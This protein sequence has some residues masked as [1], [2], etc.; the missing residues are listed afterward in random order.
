M[1][2]ATIRSP[3]DVTKDLLPQGNRLVVR[4]K[5]DHKEFKPKGKQSVTPSGCRYMR[6]T[7]IWQTVWLEGV[8]TT[9]IRDWTV[10]AEPVSGRLRL[11]MHLDGPAAGLRAS[12]RVSRAGK[13]V[14]EDSTPCENGRASLAVTV[15]QPETWTPDNPALYDLALALES[16]QGQTVDRVET[17]AGFRTIE[18]RNGQFYLNAKPFFLISALD[19][20]YYPDGL[21]TAPTD[22]ALRADVQW[23]KRFGL[24]SVRKHQI[25]A[26]PRYLYWCDRLGLTVWGEMADWGESYANL[27]RFLKQWT[28][29]VRRDLN[30]PCI[31]TW[32][33]CNERTPYENGQGDE[34]MLSRTGDQIYDATRELDP[35]RPI[36]DNSGYNH[37]KTDIVDFHINYISSE[38]WRKWWDQW[39]QAIAK[40]GN[41]R[42]CDLAMAFN[43]G[44]RYTGQPV[45]MSEE[46]HLWMR[47]CRPLNAAWQIPDWK[48]TFAATP[49]QYVALYRD[50]VLTLMNER[51]CAGFS[52]VQLYD[53]EG[54]LNGYLTYDRRP[55][56]PPEAISAV[57][58]QGLCER[59]GGR[60]PENTTAQPQAK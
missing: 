13:Q 14:A 44:Y 52:Y 3:F 18:I 46:G 29:C 45:V 28:A 38:A 23:S 25:V 12:V 26:D 51:D 22:A 20:G 49:D 21:Y 33:P 41:M 40:S 17:Y 47:D 37:A 58:A 2:A 10:H 16:P 4:V 9:F 30:H 34:D 55:K 53:V 57:H 11:E 5:D 27:P 36:V 15:A 32:V 43:K 42:I 1:K 31:I 48:Q 50:Q 24:N 19:Q 39:R 8:G 54:E 6:T 60:R 35:S 59:A 56:I 7:G